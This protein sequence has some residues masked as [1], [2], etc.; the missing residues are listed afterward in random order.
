MSKEWVNHTL[1]TT[2]LIN[3]ALMRF[4]Q[5]DRIDWH[6]RSHFLFDRSLANASD[7]R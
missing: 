7:T 4:L 2:A 1:K 6:S 3:E 5:A